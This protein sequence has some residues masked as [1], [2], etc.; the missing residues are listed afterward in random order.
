MTGKLES[1]E[2]LKEKKSLIFP[3]SHGLISAIMN[4]TL[5]ETT[6]TVYF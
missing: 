1:F 5:S 3:D 2:N 6:Q 4:G